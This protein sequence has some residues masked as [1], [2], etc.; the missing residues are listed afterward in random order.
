LAYE[1]LLGVRE[2]KKEKWEDEQGKRRERYYVSFTYI[3]HMAWKL[4]M[5]L[6]GSEA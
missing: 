5:M 1:L 3:F 6:E 2:G 4:E